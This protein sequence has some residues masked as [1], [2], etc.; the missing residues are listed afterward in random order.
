MKQSI[1][2]LFLVTTGLFS[3]KQGNNSTSDNT[4]NSTQKME[5]QKILTNNIDKNIYTKYEYNE[6]NGTRLIIKTSFP[7]GGQKY[8]DFKGFRL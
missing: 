7:R 4:L 5:E 2:I 8:T 3:C 1:I 6:S